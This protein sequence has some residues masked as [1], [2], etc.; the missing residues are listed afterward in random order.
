VKS[1]AVPLK[2]GVLLLETGAGELSVTV[3]DAVLMVN[4]CAPLVRVLPA[5]A[6]CVTC[7][8]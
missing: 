4:V 6:Y 2:E 7:A 3:G 1:L 5:L 8:V